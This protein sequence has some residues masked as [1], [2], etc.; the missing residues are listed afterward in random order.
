[1]EIKLR[2][3]SENGLVK[4]ETINL[5]GKLQQRGIN[6]QSIQSTYVSNPVIEAGSV[7]IILP[8]QEVNRTNYTL[9]KDVPYNSEVSVNIRVRYDQNDSVEE[10]WNVDVYVDLHGLGL[11]RQDRLLVKKS[12]QKVHKFPDSE[13]IKVEWWV[14]GIEKEPYE[15]KRSEI[16]SKSTTG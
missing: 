7:G 8:L 1:M 9:Y 11:N 16:V 15:L 14:N 13:I 2:V 4:E 6:N 3:S 12:P 10:R 5:A